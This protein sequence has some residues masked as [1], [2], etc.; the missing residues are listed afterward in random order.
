ML[1]D[2]AG[3]RL[4]GRLA[5][6]ESDA[7]IMPPP[8]VPP[9]T[10]HK[11]FVYICQGEYGIARGEDLHFTT[12]DATTCIILALHCPQTGTAALAHCD[13]QADIQPMIEYMHCPSA[14][15]VGA[16]DA[17]HT[18]HAVLD[19]LLLALDTA[20]Q[21]ITLHLACVGM[22]NVDQLG[23]PIVTAMSIDAAT[24][25]VWQ[26]CCEW[27]CVLPHTAQIRWFVTHIQQPCRL[28]PHWATRSTIHPAHG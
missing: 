4:Q 14:Y 24:G 3:N 26:G 22:H 8:P 17:S 7:E 15:L 18:T 6:L 2:T 25:A 5:V 21:P 9:E 12:S 23:F 19:T 1:L 20:P 10:N 16:Y 13:S 28:N 11:R 27:V